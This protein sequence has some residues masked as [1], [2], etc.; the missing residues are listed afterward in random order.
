MCVY[1]GERPFKKAEGGNE[2]DDNEII[3]LIKEEPSKG[4]Y[5]A[6]KKYRG[7]AA[8]IA[9]RVLPE[10]PQDI[11]E[12]V[13]DVFVSVWKYINCGSKIQNLKGFVA[14]AVRNDAIN[15]LKKLKREN[16][17]EIGNIEIPSDDDLIL[18]FE[19]KSNAADVRRFIF[20]MD[21]PYREIFVRR[22]FLFESIRDISKHMMLDRIQ[23]KNRLYRGRLKLRRQLEERNVAL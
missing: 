5:E 1:I 22:Y 2:L 8:A 18:D 6:V 11:E 19:N 16:S 9:Q 4:L 17:G 20:E 15:R 14:C 12:C 21:E 3:L 23:I 7:Y 13:S 10:K